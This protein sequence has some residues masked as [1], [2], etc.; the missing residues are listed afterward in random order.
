MEDD[1]GTK[2]SAVVRSQLFLAEPLHARPAGALV[3]LLGAC[4]DELRIE[5]GGRSADGRSILS[6]M[7]LGADAGATVTV[8]VSGPT[9]LATMAAVEHILT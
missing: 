6:L 2:S 8:E 3:R 9:A 7:A 4:S 1:G 5:M